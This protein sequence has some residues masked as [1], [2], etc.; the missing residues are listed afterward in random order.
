MRNIYLAGKMSGLPEFNFPAF[1]AAT[2]RLRAQGHHVFN[3]AERDIIRHGGVDI[4]KGNVTGSQEQAR[5][6]HSFSLEDALLEDLTFIIKGDENGPCTTIALLPGWEYSGG[7]F[8][9]FVTAKHFN[10]EFW[11]L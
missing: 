7:A 11:Y 9:E 3:P 8:L 6:E 10:K 1:N 2:E 5:K 4:S